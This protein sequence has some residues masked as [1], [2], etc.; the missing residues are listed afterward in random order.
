MKKKI[1]IAYLCSP[2][3]PKKTFD[4]FLYHYKKY[5]PGVNH[6]LII[7]YKNLISSEITYFRKK[8]KM[9][10]H[11]EFIDNEKKNDF[12]FGTNKRLA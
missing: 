10:K 3:V 4:E 11:N 5:K 6:Q 7:C 1:I 2:Y 12:D 8:L 9:I